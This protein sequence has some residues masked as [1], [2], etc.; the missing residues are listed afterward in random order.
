MDPTIARR[1]FR[2]LEPVHGMIYFAPEAAERYAALGLRGRSGYFASR[3]APMGAVPAE[4]VIA[5]FFNFWPELV[6]GAIPAAWE[7]VTPAQVLD[8]RLAAADAALRRALGDEVAS[9]GVVEAA[10]LA[11]RAAE[12]ACENPEGR[13]LFAGHVA[14]PWPDDP[15][16]VLWH[17]QTLLREYRGDGHIAAL[18]GEG[19]NALDALITHA[20]M[21]EVPAELLPRDARRGPK[22][23]GRPASSRSRA[24]G[25][26]GPGPEIVFSDAGRQ[27]RDVIE[28]RT[29][30][31]AVRAYEPLG[32]DG[33]ARLRALGRVVSRAVID[34]G[35]LN[36]GAAR[37]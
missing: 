11:R 24:R 1:T 28:A 14:L 27:V 30:A 7:I 17:A 29:D 25:L 8:A 9:D 13:P 31:L 37:R 22:T 3:A 20:A 19:F 5:T 33:C 26:L 32:E 34:A 4:V 21:N 18:V 15:H 23:S 10:G 35:L 6:R 16:L 36:P 2:T 12:V